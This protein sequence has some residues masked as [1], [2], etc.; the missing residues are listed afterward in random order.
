MIGT[1]GMKAGSFTV[2]AS[3]LLLVTAASAAAQRAQQPI[4]IPSPPLLPPPLPLG[5]PAAMTVPDP[6]G[7]MQPAGPDIYRSPDGSDR[8]LKTAPY[9]PPPMVIPPVGGGYLTWPYYQ[10]GPAPDWRHTPPRPVIPRGGLTLETHPDSAQ[11]YVDGFYVGVVQDFGIRGRRLELSEGS[12]HVELRAPDYD[13][14]S[15][16]VM[17]EPYD[18]VRYRGDMHALQTAAPRAQQAGPKKSYYV[19]P[20][21]YA[22]DK[23]PA[24]ALPDRCDAKKL[25]TLK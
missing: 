23:P 16:N 15:F 2:L 11:V 20:Y 9:P 6:L 25:Q 5:A 4:Y 18:L 8:F 1:S 12:H 13:T 10:P 21:C 17:I 24:R 14:L 19:I 22:G 3:A 7:P